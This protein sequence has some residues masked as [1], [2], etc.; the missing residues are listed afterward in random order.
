MGIGR[1]KALL[2][3]KITDTEVQRGVRLALEGTPGDATH[4]STRAMPPSTGRCQRTSMS[5]QLGRLGAI[6]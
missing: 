2:V 1:P 4:W 5:I 3:V 6:G